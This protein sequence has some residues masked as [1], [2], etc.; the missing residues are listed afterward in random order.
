MILKFPLG[1]KVESEDDIIM[2]RYD[3]IVDALNKMSNKLDS[4]HPKDDFSDGS[5]HLYLGKHYTLRI[6]RGVEYVEIIGDEIV[7]TASYD[8]YAEQLMKIFYR[9]MAYEVVIPIFSDMV[10]E[11]EKRHGVRPIALDF[12]YVKSYWGK[13]KGRGEIILN[14]ELMR[15]PLETIRYIISH[16][17]C[18]LIHRNH[19]PQFYEL[20]TDEMPDWRKYKEMLD[21]SL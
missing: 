5:K 18:H 1:Y 3:W 21:R 12:K 11:F 6:K 20:L 16:E 17:L 15:A 13:C 7:V 8:Y 19:S 4:N 9:N 14:L 10:Y 2:K